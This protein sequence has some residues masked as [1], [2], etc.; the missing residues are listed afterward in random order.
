MS[1]VSNEFNSTLQKH[2]A[3]LDREIV[4]TEGILNF[5]ANYT[6]P[7]FFNPAYETWSIEELIDALQYAIDIGVI[8]GAKDFTKAKE[9]LEQLKQQRATFKRVNFL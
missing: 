2:L 1:N 6:A 3:M 7:K 4:K 9:Q 8:K 5:W